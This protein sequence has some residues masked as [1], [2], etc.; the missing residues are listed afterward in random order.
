M[1][2]ENIICISPTNGYFGPMIVVELDRQT[3]ERLIEEKRER[4]TQL[5]GE[6]TSLIAEVNRLEAALKD[7]TKDLKAG[8]PSLTEPPKTESGRIKRGESERLIVEFL[9]SNRAG[10]V[11]L[12]DLCKATAVK[13]GTAARII[14]QLS[15]SKRIDEVNG[16]WIWG[17]KG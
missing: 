3:V 15:E 6:M 9:S 2:S 8:R 10:A 4:V 14:R 11:S 13:Y 7:D 17:N 12:A 5:D 1:E 16:K